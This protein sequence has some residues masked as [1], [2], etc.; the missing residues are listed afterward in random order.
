MREKGVKKRVRGEKAVNEKG[1]SE[2]LV[3]E[4]KKRV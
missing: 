4:W 3:L 2:K 1:M